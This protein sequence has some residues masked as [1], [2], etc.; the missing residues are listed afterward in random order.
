MTVD[1]VKEPF[2]DPPCFPLHL[3]GEAGETGEIDE[4]GEMDSMA[5]L[6]IFSVSSSC[7]MSPESS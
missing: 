5:M 6:V 3:L 7:W 1:A 4:T 2:F